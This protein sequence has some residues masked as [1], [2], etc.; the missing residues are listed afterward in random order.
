MRSSVNPVPPALVEP[1]DMK[2]IDRGL[3][4]LVRHVAGP[5]L[6]DD[7]GDFILLTRP[8]TRVLVAVDP[9]KRFATKE[10]RGKN[11]RS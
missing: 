2:G 3:D 4:L 10:S 6:G 11:A 1:V 8:P 9:D 5:K 7:Q